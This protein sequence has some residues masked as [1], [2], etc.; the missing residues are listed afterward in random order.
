[1]GKVRIVANWQVRYTFHMTE[2]S[3]LTTRDNRQIAYFQTAGTAPGVVFLGGYRSDMMGTKATHLEKWAQSEGRAFVRFDYSGHG[4]SGGAFEEGCIGDWTDDARAVVEALTTGPQILVGSSMGGWVALLLARSMPDRVAGLV[5]ISA[6]PDFMQE[7]V[8][9][10]ATAEQRAELMSAGRVEMPSSTEDTPDVITRRMIEDG[11]L[12]TVLGRPLHLPM[13]LRLLHGSADAEVPVSTALRL[14]NHATG[15]DIRL[16]LVN[17]ADHRFS[18]PDCLA[19]I[20][21]TV[22]DICGM[23]L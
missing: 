21:K 23:A 14:F 20:Q 18:T 17:G 1:L 7:L 4:Q 8:W 3:W 12:Q 22:S 16:T 9:D 11:R 19:L 10:T 15:P 13:P 2:L 6:A 5:G